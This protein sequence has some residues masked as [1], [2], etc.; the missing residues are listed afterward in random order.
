MRPALACNAVPNATVKTKRARSAGS[1]SI[2]KSPASR[3]RINLAHNAI[4]IP[5]RRSI[6]VFRIGSASSEQATAPFR[7]EAAGRCFRVGLRIDI[8]IDQSCNGDVDGRLSQRRFNEAHI[9]GV[10]ELEGPTEQLLLVAKSSVKTGTRDPHCIGE[11]RHRRPVIAAFSQNSLTADARASVASNS[12]GRAMMRYVRFL[13][14]G[15]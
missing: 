11:I 3:A 10:I 2:G 15:M 5:T 13:P 8:S 12:F 6:S 7:G 4:S 9:F 1:Q 14:I